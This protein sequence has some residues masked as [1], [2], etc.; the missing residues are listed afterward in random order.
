MIKIKY[1][2]TLLIIASTVSIFAQTSIS[3]TIKDSNNKPIEGATVVLNTT[4]HLYGTTNMDGYF[5]INNVPT[6]NY[7]L[8]ISHLGYKTIETSIEVNANNKTFSYTLQTDLL[9]LHTVVV[10]G[11]FNPRTHIESNTSVSTLTAKDIQQVYPQGTANLLQN[12]PGTFADASAGEVF[13]KVYTRGISAAAED[14][15]GWYYVSLQEDGLPVSLVQHS[16]YGS[17]LFHRTDLTTSKV[18]A[19]RGGSASITAM[20]APGGVYNFIS[21]NY[22]EDLSGEI[23]LQS[24]IQGEGNP[25][26]R[27]D[28]VLGGALGNDWFFN[29]GGHYRLDEGARNTDFTFSKGGQFK[30]NVIKENSSGYLKLY[31]KYLNDYTNR[32]NGLAAT[33][34]NNPKA[35]F[36]LDFNSTALMMPEFH[37]NIPDG[38]NLNNTNSFDPSQG[39]HAKDLAFG[40]DVFQ[41]LGNSWSFKNNMKF[42]SKSANWQTSISNAFVSISDPTVYALVSYQNPFPAGQI[43]FRDANSGN[44]LAR[45]DNTGVTSGEPSEYLTAGTLPNDAVMGTSTW[46][47]DNDADEFMQQFTLRK[48]WENHDLNFGL[49]SGFSDTSVFTQGSFAFSTY[50]NNPRILQVTLENPGEPVMALSDAYGVSNYGALFFTNSR[51]N[52]TQLATFANDRWKL[53]DNIQLDL[54]VRFETIKHKG[55]NDRFAPFTQSGGLDGDENTAYDNNILQPTGEQDA[56]NYTYNYVS[57]STGINYKI[58]DDAAL[59]GRFSKGHKAPE[60]NYYFNNFANVPINKKGEVQ[61]INQ[62]EL[63][64]KSNLKDFSFATTLFWSE[65]KNIGVTN[66]EFDEDT[67]S[68]FYTPIQFNTSRTIGLEWESVYTPLEY[69]AFRFN[70]VIQNP[71]AT[72][73][74][75][76]DAADSVDTSDDSTTDYSGNT[77]PSNPKLMFNVVA[78]YNKNKT[79]S[80]IKWRYMGKREGNVANAFQLA[81]YSVFDAGIGYKINSHLSANILATNLLNSD[82][83]ANFYGAN[84][85]AANANGATSEFIEANP[86]A[87]F[88]VVPILPRAILLQLNYKI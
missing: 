58:T 5:N 84:T 45:I 3:G 55:S 60:L 83:L 63:G 38:R 34:W 20:N 86:D 50:E 31:G 7:N 32:Y 76:Y 17:D 16:Y 59:F 72:K 12:I 64:L 19:L 33:D 75:I 36:G 18:E 26:Y 42:S 61:D 71:K 25:L 87:S 41:N 29:A 11:T 21:R 47:K 14:D 62:V 10:T 79:A 69:F 4:S 44:E 52:I 56:F 49:A 1:I 37:A 74:F 48:E 22:T 53:S 9:N 66:F 23:Q 28:G 35:A 73:W 13:T 24:G 39:V 77:L 82:G 51:A 6:G 81:A 15:L 67:S 40:F 27:V 8:I 54:G 65:L 43:V 30:F 2:I 88:V 78:E 57:Y 80:F 85:F 70:G 68:I 46:Y